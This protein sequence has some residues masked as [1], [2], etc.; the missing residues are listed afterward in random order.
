[1]GGGGTL[2]S[3]PSTAYA[4]PFTAVAQ[5]LDV[6]LD[7]GLT[8]EQARERLASVGPNRLAGGKKES[9]LAA[10]VRQYRDFM[11]IILLVAAVVNLIVTQDVAT[12]VVLAGL[13]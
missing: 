4:Q 3:E 6:D 12:S 2:A 8:V 5:K 1:M 10:F 7:K 11:Q 9:A 13:T